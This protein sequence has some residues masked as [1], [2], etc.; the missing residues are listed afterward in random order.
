LKRSWFFEERNGN[1]RLMADLATQLAET[2]STW[3]R[4]VAPVAEWAMKEFAATTRT[5]KSI[6]PTRLTQDH[7]RSVAG[8]VISS[9]PAAMLRQP[10]MCNVC[11]TEI[12]GRQRSCL[13]CSLVPSAE[14]LTA[15]AAKGL[16]ASHTPEAQA[17][18]SKKHHALH[19]ARRAWNAS[20]QPPW[21]TEEFYVSKM[22]PKLVSQSSRGIARCLNVSLR[23]AT[24]IRH[25]R[26]PHPRHWQSLAK[27]VAYPN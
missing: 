26:V 21:L 8:G 25:G 10:N 5:R 23:Y 16:I 7:K 11:G 9:K 19:T 20:N 12:G 18:R 13:T 24:E 17:K 6:S 27:L 14:R 3:A 2:T 15:V 4:L 22:K 1:C